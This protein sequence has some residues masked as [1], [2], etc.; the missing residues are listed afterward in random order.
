MSDASIAG[1]TYMDQFDFESRYRDHYNCDPLYWHPLH[2]P[3]YCASMYAKLISSR[4]ANPYQ[5]RLVE[6][7]PK[8]RT[9][10]RN[11]RYEEYEDVHQ[12]VQPEVKTY[13]HFDRLMKALYP[14]GKGIRGNPSYAYSN[15]G[16]VAVYH[17]PVSRRNGDMI[18]KLA[19]SSTDTEY[20][21]DRRPKRKRT[22]KYLLKKKK[23]PVYVSQSIKSKSPQNKKI[24]N[25]NRPIPN[26][27]VKKLKAN[28]HNLQIPV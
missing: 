21:K 20:K 5:I 8:E 4:L 10:H 25:N 15:L 9:Y 1:V 27:N 13:N 12:K 23:V 17:Q 26:K 19:Q 11:T 16:P 2:L 22:R 14:D 3:D 7:V 28:S 6:P 24:V 18:K